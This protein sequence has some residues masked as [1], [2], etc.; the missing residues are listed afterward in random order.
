MSDYVKLTNFTA[1][2]SLPSGDPDKV[3]RGS[4]FDAE[5]NSI[6]VAI[7]SKAEKS[8]DGKAYLTEETDPTVPTHVK[9]ITQDN[10][11]FWNAGGGG[12]L[13]DAPNDGKLYGRQ[14]QTWAE[15]PEGGVSDWADIE[16]KPTEFPPS[17][18]MHEISQVN[19]LQ[20]ALDNAGG[21]SSVTYTLPV[22]LRSGNAQLPLTLDGTKLA[23]MTRGG[24]LELPLAA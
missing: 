11:D 23:V 21:G 4:E 13:S 24:E 9:D 19:G 7:E 10:I 8:A 5:F 2:D 20:D 14:S 15:V 16:N 6:Q 12:S 3:V 1:K 18:H 22:A 17:A